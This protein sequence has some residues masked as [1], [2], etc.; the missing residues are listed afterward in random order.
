[1]DAKAT[2]NAMLIPH[3]TT[4][5]MEIHTK[6]GGSPA[7]RPVDGGMRQPA[8]DR[9]V[10]CCDHVAHS[11]EWA[12]MSEFGLSEIQNPPKISVRTVQN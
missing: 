7:V 1:M 9:M 4:R 8:A 2:G 12:P 3:R 5:W 6:V 10:A 11:C